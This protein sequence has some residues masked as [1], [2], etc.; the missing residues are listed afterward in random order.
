MRLR[1]RSPELQ[2]QELPARLLP[3]GDPSHGFPMVPVEGGLQLSLEAALQTYE[4]I[5]ATPEERGGP[6]AVG[7][8]VRQGPV[9]SAQTR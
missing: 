8:H 6:P 4:V 7:A 3:G 2:G 9:R 1:A 5:D